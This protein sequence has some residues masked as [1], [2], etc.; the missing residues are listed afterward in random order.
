MRANS[1]IV[2]LSPLAI[3]AENLKSGWK[4]IPDEP[5]MHLL[6]GAQAKF[7]FMSSAIVF[8]VVDAQKARLGF[9]TTRTDIS[10]IGSINLLFGFIPAC[11]VAGVDIGSPCHLLL[12]C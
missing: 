8:N 5:A 3:H 1:A 11:L 7:P 9:S 6:A 2:S 4:L 12:W 10:A